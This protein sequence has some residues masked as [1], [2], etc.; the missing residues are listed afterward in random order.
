MSEKPP[1]YSV[2]DYNDCFKI[3]KK[4]IWIKGYNRRWDGSL[5]DLKNNFL[6][7][8]KDLGN[9]LTTEYSIKAG[10]TYLDQKHH[11]KPVLKSKFFGGE[12]NNYPK[13]LHSKYKQLYEMHWNS[14]CHYLDL[15]NY[16]N[17]KN[18]KNYKTS[19][20]TNFF[21]TNFEAEL[22]N[23]NVNCS[24]NI[25]NSK[26][27]DWYE[28]LFF[29]FAHGQISIKFFSP[30]YTGSGHEVLINYSSKN[31]TLV[32]KKLNDN[33]F[34]NQAQGFVNLIKGMIEGKQNSKD[35]IFSIQTYENLWKNYLENNR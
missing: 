12:K 31:K 16:F 33:S 11:S 1:V 4:N 34:K 18:L 27:I 29:N 19:L 22:N 3:Q 24:L 14:T 35:G 2:K 6:K 23:S 15:Y 9:L 17:F 30:L 13:F 26:V 7:Y 20:G 5:N 10:N 25:V 8:S 21:V 28:K 32:L